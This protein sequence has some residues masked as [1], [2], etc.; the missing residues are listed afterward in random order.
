MQATVRH[1]EIP[2]RDFARASRFYAEVFGWRIEP[3]P[4]EG[5]PYARIRAALPGTG[6]PRLGIDGGL[7]TAGSGADQPL[8][9][10]HIEGAPLDEC[11]ER[12]VAA[13]GTLDQPATRIADFG[14]FAR[15]RDPEGNLLGL[16][17]SAG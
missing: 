16:W 14:C 4:W 10:L 3:L 9:V 15:F 1:F 5:P 17:Q 6:S 12:I 7:T 8:L 11:L 13:G 2:A